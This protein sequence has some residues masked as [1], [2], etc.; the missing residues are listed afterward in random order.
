MLRPALI[1]NQKVLENE[2]K[3]QL[4]ILRISCIFENKYRSKTDYKHPMQYDFA[5]FSL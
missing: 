4:F 3:K 1:M 2:V 5:K